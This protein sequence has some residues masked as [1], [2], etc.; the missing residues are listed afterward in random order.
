MSILR[1]ASRIIV[2]FAAVSLAPAWVRDARSQV[3]AHFLDV[4]ASQSVLTPADHVRLARGDS[5]A[6]VLDAELGQVAVLAMV[7]TRATPESLI[8]SVRDIETLKRSTYVR[9]IR[10]F[11]SAPVLSDL[12]ELRVSPEDRKD[13]AGCTPTDCAI[14]LTREELRTLG[15]TAGAAPATDH[16]DHAFR[17]VVLARV[18]RYLRDGGVVAEAHDHPPGPPRPFERIMGA[19]PYVT[20]AFPRFAAYLRQ[21]PRDGNRDIESFLY[22]SVESF[23]RKP[24]VV[25]T[26]VAILRPT[27]EERARGVSV[28]VAGKQIFATHYMDASL[29]LTALVDHESRRYLTYVNRSETDALG[30]MFGWLKRA[31]VERRIRTE[32]ASILT[33][34]RRRV[35]SRLLPE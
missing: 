30:G 7:D 27:A 35:E 23:G 5:V 33:G 29:S 3:P 2:G 13:I 31:V 8:A 12:D 20:D 9:T 18:Q 17:A 10:R 16:L 14:K 22:W 1:A 28:L 4:L 34:V 11:S 15:D 6:R 24:V 32:A 25:V 19:S 21:F 26:H